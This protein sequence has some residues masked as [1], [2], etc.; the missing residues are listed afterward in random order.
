MSVLIEAAAGLVGTDCGGKPPTAAIERSL[1]EGRHSLLY[2]GKRVPLSPFLEQAARQTGQ[3]ALE[4]LRQ[5]LR[6]E[7]T[8]VD[9]ILLTGGGS[10]LFKPLVRE[11]FSPV[12]LHVPTDSVGANARGYFYYGAR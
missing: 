11:R 12:P 4:A 3:V 2:R 9:L 8:E 1:A 5:D 10:A 7:H 6:R